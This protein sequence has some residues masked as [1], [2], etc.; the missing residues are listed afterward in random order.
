LKDHDKIADLYV[1]LAHLYNEGYR[2]RYDPELMA[3]S[4]LPDG[5]EIIE[6]EMCFRCGYEERYSDEFCKK[7]LNVWGLLSKLDSSKYGP[8]GTEA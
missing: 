1:D 3:A 4:P 7:Y 2:C 5:M 8:G 6:K